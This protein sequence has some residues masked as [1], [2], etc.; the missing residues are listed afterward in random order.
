[1]DGMGADEALQFLASKGLE[2]AKGIRRGVRDL[3]AKEAV[4][5]ALE[6]AIEAAEKHSKTNEGSRTWQF[7]LTAVAF[8]R[9]RKDD[10]DEE[11]EEMEGPTS[12]SSKRK[13]ADLGVTEKAW[14]YAVK[15]A[16]QLQTALQPTE[17][18]KNTVY[19]N[20]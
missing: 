20:M 10:Q 14:P 7:F 9:P 15:R 19:W 8:R 4:G 18:I 6:R 12:M 17:A 3:S 2:A 16:K 13:A 1:M 5:V 11:E